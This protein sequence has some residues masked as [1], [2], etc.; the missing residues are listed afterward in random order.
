[1]WCVIFIYSILYIKKIE[2]KCTNAEKNPYRFANFFVEYAANKGRYYA[3]R[4][5]FT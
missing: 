1:M 3:L 2:G 5:D 4:Y